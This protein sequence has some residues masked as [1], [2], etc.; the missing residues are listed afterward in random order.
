L[1][2]YFEIRNPVP[3]NRAA[4]TYD[5][6]LSAIHDLLD[7]P[8]PAPSWT[9]SFDVKCFEKTDE[10]VGICFNVV[11]I[12][13]AAISDRLPKIDRTRFARL[14]VEMAARLILLPEC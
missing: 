2:H 14:S 5:F 13:E 6:G 11:K 10:V 1:P 8:A 9:L 4:S 7:H 12:R 3:G